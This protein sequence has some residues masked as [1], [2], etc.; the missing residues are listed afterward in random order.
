MYGVDCITCRGKFPELHFIFMAETKI[1]ERYQF[2]RIKN[3]LLEL[4]VHIQWS[5]IGRTNLCL[6]GYISGQRKI[7][8]QELRWRNKIL[9]GSKPDSWSPYKQGAIFNWSKPDWIEKFRKK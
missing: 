8:R 1:K 2:P 6:V 4:F 5:K 9:N 7:G 3:K